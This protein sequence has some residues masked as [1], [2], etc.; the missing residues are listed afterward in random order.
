MFM[1]VR[2]KM[3]AAKDLFPFPESERN[4]IYIYLFLFVYKRLK[5]HIVWPGINDFHV[6]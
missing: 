5:V 6:N 2:Y 3:N 1:L 4:S